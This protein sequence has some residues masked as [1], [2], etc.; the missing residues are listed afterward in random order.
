MRLPLKRLKT[1]ESTPRQPAD[2]VRCALDRRIL[3][4]YRAIVHNPRRKDFD[5]KI[6]LG[7]PPPL[8]T[9]T[10]EAHCSCTLALCLCNAAFIAPGT[11]VDGAVAHPMLQRGTWARMRAQ[12]RLAKLVNL[13]IRGRQIASPVRRA[14]SNFLH[15][16]LYAIMPTTCK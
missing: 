5:L 16:L 4:S 14:G 15:L 9:H 7:V 12:C 11:S 13:C 8:S 6:L 1:S 10:F 3:S 2:F